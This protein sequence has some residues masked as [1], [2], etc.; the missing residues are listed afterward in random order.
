MDG[1]SIAVTYY[2]AG[3]APTDYPSET[4]WRARCV[5]AACPWCLDT[6]CMPGA[7]A[8]ARSGAGCAPHGDYPQELS[9]ARQSCA[10]G[11]RVGRA[12][13]TGGCSTE[14]CPAQ[15]AQ[16]GQQPAGAGAGRCWSAAPARSAP[17]LPTSWRAPRRCSRTWPRR[18]CWRASWSSRTRPGS[19]EPASQ[20]LHAS[21]VQQGHCCQVHSHSPLS[22]LLVLLAH[23]GVLS[24]DKELLDRRWG[25]GEDMTTVDWHWQE[26]CTV[27]IT[28]K[29]PKQIVGVA[30]YTLELHR[31]CICR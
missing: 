30:C 9:D 22:S 24:K 17:R 7:P 27:L 16:Q 12:G 28:C 1:T 10:Q 11:A 23:L 8:V 19:S 18:A 26:G 4:E 13:R 3:Y 20:V 14:A 6:C 5:R 29:R 25:F 2:R 21:L 15:R 31:P